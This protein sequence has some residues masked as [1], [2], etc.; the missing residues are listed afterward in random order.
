MSIYR[1]INRQLIGNNYNLAVVTQCDVA[2]WKFSI[3]A[4][5]NNKKI[6]I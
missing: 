3:V 5:E 4:E 1:I 6:L 2:F